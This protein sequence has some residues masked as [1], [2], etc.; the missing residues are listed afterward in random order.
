L[1]GKYSDQ[2]MVWLKEEGYTHCLYLAGG[3]S[4]HLLD[5]AS[6]FF[7]CI[8]FVHEAS[9]AIA[10]EY[11]NESEGQGK[12]FCLV[13]TGPGLTNTITAIAGAWLESHELLILAGQVK[14]TDLASGGIRQR[15]IQELPGTKIAEPI[16]NAVF[17][18]NRQIPESYFKSL[19]TDSQN[20]RKGPVV[21]EVCID[22]SAAPVAPPTED[23][24]DF[25]FNS[26]GNMD[27]PEQQL[28]ELIRTS[29]RPLILL[30]G[31]VTRATAK[32]FMEKVKKTK[33]PVS[34]TWAGA[35][36]VSSEYTSYAGRPNTFGMRWANVFQQQADLLI[37]V[38]TRLGLQ[39][40]GFNWQQF[41]PVGQVVLVDI[42]QSEIDKGHPNIHLGINMDSSMFL[43]NLVPVIESNLSSIEP[44]LDKLDEIQ[45]GLPLLEESQM[46]SSEFVNPYEL[47]K[48]V[49]TNT[50]GTDIFTPGTSGGTHTAFYQTF[51][52]RAGQKIVSNKGLASMGYGLAGA[53]G[54]ALA[55]P[56][57][58]IFN[59]EGDGSFSQNLQ[60]L[61]TVSRNNLNIKM[62]IINNNGYASI[63]SSQI[64]Y[65]GGNYLG[66]DTKS[67]L[68]FP[69]WEIL[70]RA[71]FIEYF[72]ITPSTLKSGNFLELINANKPVLFEV[73]ADPEQMYLPKIT[74]VI[75]EDG[76]MT[77]NP[78]HKMSPEIDSEMKNTVFEYLP[79]ALW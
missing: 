76:T 51:Y 36:R 8:P 37:A 47:I 10:T 31:G 21:I 41:C 16:S 17:Q 44:W 65:F 23:N 18:I 45:K 4:M 66:C 11:F 15:G 73:I 54:A 28:T 69:D 14:T 77:S 6:K 70:S 75:N 64:A 5:S 30:G 43:E 63:R 13:T 38:G 7:K 27:F 25:T 24:P 71:F 19:V 56:K 29:K 57:S 58:R 79:K 12:A 52:N 50:V 67:G 2:I 9:A 35:D 72:R 60:E 3:G 22:I 53:I 48:L 39:Q 42:D 32:T 26:P 55:N 59:F 61:A 46:V 74:S 40:T 33:I 49:E 1:I 78:L 34:S 62:F 68:G 20:G